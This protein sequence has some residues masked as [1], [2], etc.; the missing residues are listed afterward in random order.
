MTVPA[1]GA[2]EPRKGIACV[3]EACAHFYCTLI[4]KRTY[5]VLRYAR[6][7]VAQICWVLVPKV[8]EICEHGLLL[9]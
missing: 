3:Y 7:V 9:R 5:T 1:K 6:R 8:D 2:I 4:F